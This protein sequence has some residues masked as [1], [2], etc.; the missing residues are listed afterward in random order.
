M[1]EPTPRCRN[2][3]R[4][5]GI[6]IAGLILTSGIYDLTDFPL[7]D[8][9]GYIG[10]RYLALAAR[11]P[12]GGLRYLPVPALIVGAELDPPPFI[13]PQYDRLVAAMADDTGRQAS[14]SR[15]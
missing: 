6:G 9:H 7:T 13:D 10:D 8:N 2:S 1:P 15:D 14:R 4:A 5:K 12:I 3:R 11:S